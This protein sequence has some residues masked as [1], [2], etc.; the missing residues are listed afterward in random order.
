M[1]TPATSIYEA[2]TRFSGGPPTLI[3]AFNADASRA[4]DRHHT[5]GVSKRDMVYCE[6]HP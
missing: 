5:A 3:H 4:L 1:W 2:L 6:S